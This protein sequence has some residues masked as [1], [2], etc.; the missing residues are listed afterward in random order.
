MTAGHTLTAADLHAVAAQMR[1]A[2]EPPAGPLSATPLTGG[3]SNLTYRLDDGASSWVLRTPPRHGRTP[4]AHDVTREFTVTRALVGTGVPVAHPVLLCED[5]SVLGV[6]FLLARFAPGLSVQTRTQLDKLA[7]DT[8]SEMVRAL[9]DALVALHSVDYTA[10]GLA[11]FGRPAG[12]AQRQI[13]RWT[14]QW[15]H[16]GDPNLTPLA[17]QLSTRLASIDFAQDFTGIVHGDYRIDN[18]LI[19]IGERSC[20]VRINAIVDW[21]LSTI[22]DPTADVAMMC[23]YRH[24]ALDLVLGF[25]SAWASPGLPGAD[26]LAAAYE[27]SSGRSLR[28]WDAHMALGYFKLAVIA[29]GIDHRY[30]AGAAHGAGFDTAATAVQP[31]LEA[32]MGRFAAH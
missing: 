31:L 15:T 5:E 9:L 12:Y 7:G 27:R 19:G 4:S 13:R 10:V 14:Q 2:G 28:Q 22:G 25:P 1:Q 17:E 21:E 20:A 3:R 26:D 16:V 30:R 24:P 32:G 23:V 29:A 11:D 8:V 6:P 18:T